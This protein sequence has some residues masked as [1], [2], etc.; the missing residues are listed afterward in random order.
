MTMRALIT[1]KGEFVMAK[2]QQKDL[3]TKRYRA[4]KNDK[5]ELESHQIQ[6]PLVEILR[7]TVRDGV[8]WHHV[9]NGELRDRKVAAKLKA[10]GVKPGVADLEFFWS[11]ELLHEIKPRTRVLF[12]ELKLPGR[13]LREESQVAFCVRARAIGAEYLV[14]RSV[15]EALAI[16]KE[17]GLLRKDRPVNRR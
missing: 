14:A 3:F 16:L 17:R 7:W 1:Q 10:M 12:L 2:P 5:R 8:I 15:D 4:V 6:I 11:E 13:P 9:P